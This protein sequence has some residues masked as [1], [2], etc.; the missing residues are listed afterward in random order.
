MG[1]LFTIYLQASNLTKII[2][3]KKSP[4]NILNQKKLE[5]GQKEVFGPAEG[6]CKPETWSKYKTLLA[7]F[8]NNLS[9]RVHYL[10][11]ESSSWKT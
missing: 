6:A 5:N 11:L 2:F 1:K 10:H 4:K 9:V 7:I 3:Y 8:P